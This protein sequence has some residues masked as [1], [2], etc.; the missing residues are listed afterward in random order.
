MHESC[1]IGYGILGKKIFDVLSSKI[2]IKVYNR[3]KKKLKNLKPYQIFNSIDEVFENCKIIFFLVKNEEAIK[4]YFDGLKNKKF[5]KNKIFVNLSTISYI[6]SKK[7]Y[8]FAKSCDSEWIECPT[9]GNPESLAN[10]NMPF[11][12][13][14]K[15]NKKVI[16]I[17]KII[18]NIKYLKKIDDPQILKIVHNAICANIMI[19]MADAFLIAKK[20][21]IKNKFL[22]DMLLNSGFV[23]PLVKNKIAKSKTGYSVSFSYNNMLKDLKIFNKS[24]FNYSEA[25]SNAYQVFDKYNKKTKN[26]D[27]S[28]IIQKILKK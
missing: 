20:N 23:S 17:L 19:C 7:F 25:L 26:K 18:G 15:K 16:E 4:F 14:G 1:I 3:S 8:K 21:K 10:K 22:I 11:L 27:S 12:Y 24:K 2:K 9:L 6:Y 13:A 5:L 28:Y